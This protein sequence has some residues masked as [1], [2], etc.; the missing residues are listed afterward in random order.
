MRVGPDSLLWVVVLLLSSV[1]LSRAED[2]KP[3][4]PTNPAGGLFQSLSLGSNKG[5]V[6][7]DSDSLELDYKSSNVTYRGHVQVIVQRAP[8]KRF[9]VLYHVHYHKI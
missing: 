9:N 1:A 7:I 2:A 4:P 8:V 6:Q 5:P 3:A